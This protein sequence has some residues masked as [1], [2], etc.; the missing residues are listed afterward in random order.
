MRFNY[1]ARTKK[2]EIQRGTIEAS[3][4]E[5]AVALLQQYALIVTMLEETGKQPFFAKKIEISIISKKDIVIFSRQL[6]LMFRS[7]VPLVQIFQTLAEQT[8]QTGFKEKILAMSQVVEGGTSLSQAL[9]R[10]PNLFSSFYVSLVKSGEASGT[11][12]ES[13]DYLADHLEREYFISSKII[14]A[15]IYPILVLLMVIGVLGLMV[16]VIIPQLAEVLEETGE[17]L[18]TLTLIVIAFADFIRSWGWLL[19]IFLIILAIFLFQYIKT[20]SGRKILHKIFLRIP[21]INS[22]LKMIYVS[23]FAENLATLIKGGLSISRALEITSDVVGNEVYRE[24]ISEIRNDVRRGEKM[25][26]LLSE[27]SWLF[28]P[29]LIQMV[30]VGE[31]TGTLGQTLM[32]VT[33]FYQ[34]EIERSTDALLKIIEP[35][36]VLVMGLIVGILM[37]A[38]LMPIYRITAVS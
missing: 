4:E 17:Q 36:L 27:Q 32:N 8:K 19:I 11:L 18:P 28:P 31:E 22:F 33:D 3:S 14:G 2:G 38:M 5:A 1:Q 12:S 25:S 35:L 34:K 30:V 37:V 9:S 23:R 6:S 13:L 15:M 10:Y 24:A 21:L 20:P 7:K 29:I 16:Y 26:R